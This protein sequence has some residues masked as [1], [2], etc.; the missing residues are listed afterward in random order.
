MSGRNGVA[1][2]VVGSLLQKAFQKYAISDD[3]DRLTKAKRR[4]Q[5]LKAQKVAEFAASS[6]GRDRSTASG[7]SRPDAI[8]ELIAEEDCEVCQSLLAAVAEM[9]EPKRTRGVAEYGQFKAATE[10]S[11]EAAQQVMSDSPVLQEAV[12]MVQGL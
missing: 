1:E 4:E 12:Q 10:D 2:R 8:E 5:E 11:E 9:D 7:G 6:S 3:V